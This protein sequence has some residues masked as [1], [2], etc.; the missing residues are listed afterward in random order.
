MRRLTVATGFGILLAQ[1][2]LAY[3][4]WK[5]NTFGGALIEVLPLFVKGLL[6][7]LVPYIACSVLMEKV[8]HFPVPF[9]AYLLY[10]ILGVVPRLA[11]MGEQ[12]PAHVAFDFTEA[13][14]VI[15]PALLTVKFG[16]MATLALR[17]RVTGIEEQTEGA[18]R[19]EG[20]GS[21]GE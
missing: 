18:V 7:C 15:F 9:L 20:D 17:R 12:G 1:P 16:V 14:S 11:V 3:G 21:E 5:T 19:R 10:I 2:C 13:A 6:L 8:E 4:G